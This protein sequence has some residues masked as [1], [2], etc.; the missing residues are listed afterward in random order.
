MTPDTDLGVVRRAGRIAAV[1]ASLALAAVLLV[2]GA[3]VY[4][5]DVRVQGQQ[6]RSQLSSVAQTADDATDPPPGII[7]VL[8][9]MAGRVAAS[10]EGVPTTDLLARPPGFSD[11][12]IDNTLYRAVVVDKPEGRV[13]ALLDLAP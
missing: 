1:Q 5:V 9:D 6:V 10:A 12:R 13:V 11:A 4:F 7:L 3:V 8:R 2:V